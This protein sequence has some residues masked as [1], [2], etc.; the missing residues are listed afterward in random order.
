MG[1]IEWEWGSEDN[2]CE[3]ETS[4]PCSRHLIFISSQTKFNR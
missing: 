2:E 1:V 3:L 4:A